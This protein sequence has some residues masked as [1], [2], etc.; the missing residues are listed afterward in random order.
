M[1]RTS[2]PRVCPVSICRR[3]AA[4]CSRGNTWLKC[5]SS[6]PASSPERRGALDAAGKHLR[7]DHLI[8]ATKSAPSGEL[9]GDMADAACAKSRVRGMGAAQALAEDGVFGIVALI[10]AQPA[11]LSTDVQGLEKPDAPDR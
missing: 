4:A 5:N 11:M 7:A 8:S 3:I 10:V 9:Q 2:L 6:C 1:R